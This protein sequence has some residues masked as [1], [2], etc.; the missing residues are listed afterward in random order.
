MPRSKLLDSQPAKMYNKNMKIKKPIA[1]ISA[2]ALCAAPLFNGCT[3]I[4]TRRV[5]GYYMHNTEASLV[6]TA[7]F[8]DSEVENQANE[9]WTQTKAVLT[10][11]ENS[12]SISVEN[13]Y[14]VRFNVASA[15]ERVQVNEVCYNILSEAV[16][17]YNLTCGYYN[18]AVYYSVDLYGFATRLTDESMPYDRES[19]TTLPDEKYIE[20]FKT[21]SESFC[22]IVLECANG[23]YF[24]TKPNTTVEVDGVS[25][26]L[27]IDLGGIGKGYAADR[28]SELMDSYGFEYGYFNFG[29]SSIAVKRSYEAEDGGWN[30]YFRDP[31]S[32]VG[33]TCLSACV[34]DS[35]LST[36][37]D[38]EQ[39]YEVDGVR[40]CHII[41]PTTGSPVQTGIISATVIGG[42]AAQD[43]ALTTAIMAMGL[44]KAVDFI[45]ENLTDRKVVFIYQSGENKYVIANDINYFT[46][47]AEGYAF[48]N[49]VNSSGKIV[50]NNNVA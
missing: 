2:I 46:I 20:A 24:V 18:P 13:S 15:G 23:E 11:I 41:D 32:T 31:R 30:L 50:L 9:L 42:T 19:Y 14:V 26:S 36:S 48:G 38:Y 34:S 29:T 25:Y 43:D 39:Y 17:V 45:N 8:G 7:N 6:L 12:I 27:K 37:G 40:Y 1:V 33:S 35:C 4:E 21:L 16:E 28:V 22:D 49:T 47:S 10:E 44:E 5:F 3:K